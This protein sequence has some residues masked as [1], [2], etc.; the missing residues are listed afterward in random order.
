MPFLYP[1]ATLALQDDDQ[2]AARLKRRDPESM[3]LLFDRFGSRVFNLL[4]TM[5]QDEAIAGELL[6][7]T[8]LI[9]WNGGQDAEIQRNTLEPWV[10]HIAHIRALHYLRGNRTVRHT[11]E[12]DWKRLEQPQWFRN[13]QEPYE[14]PKSAQFLEEVVANLPERQQKVIELLYFQGLSETEIAVRLGQS[15]ET[16]QSWVIAALQALRQEFGE[17]EPE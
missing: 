6:E 2:I 10:L 13:F 15:L 5:V 12:W 3:G 14:Q 11:R 1:S 8:F 17:G 16:V 4:L 9:I 7:E